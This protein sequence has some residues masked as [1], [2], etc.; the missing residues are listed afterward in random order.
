MSQG[1]QKKFIKPQVKN[2]LRSKLNAGQTA[3]EMG[4]TVNSTKQQRSRKE[5]SKEREKMD[6]IPPPKSQNFRQIDDNINVGTIGDFVIEDVPRNACML[7][8]A[9]RRSGK[10]H[11]CQHFL[12]VYTKKHKTDGIFLFS[13]TNAGFPGIPS[14]YRYKNLDVLEQIIETQIKVKKHNQLAKKK[15]K[16]KS[17]IIIILDDMVGGNAYTGQ[18]RKNPILN[19]LFVNGRHLSSDCGSSNMMVILISQVFIALAPQIRLNTDYLFTTKTASRKERENM[20]NTFLSLN[21]GRSGLAESY[22]VFDSIVNLAEFNWLVVH[23][24]AQNKKTFSDYCYNF[25]APNTLE[26]RRLVGDNEDWVNN[27]KEIYW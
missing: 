18:M 6:E 3:L 14:V 15:D 24:T 7:L 13:L 25:K 10:S 16:I 12:E 26:D 1:K 11:G 4:D 22:E 2:T 5:T 9:S 27:R 17:N 20:V 19:K 23:C 8:I 21:S